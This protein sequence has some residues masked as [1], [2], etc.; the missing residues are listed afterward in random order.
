MMNVN[1]LKFGKGNSYTPGRDFSTQQQSQLLPS[2]APNNFHSGSGFTTNTSQ[3]HSQQ[4][5][6]SKSK[7]FKTGGSIND[8]NPWMM[9]QFE[10]K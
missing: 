10:K 1:D 8:E 7:L 6:T 9:R 4:R 3:S 2:I 5:N